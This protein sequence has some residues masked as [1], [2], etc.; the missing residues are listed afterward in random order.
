MLRRMLVIRC[1]PRWGRLRIRVKSGHKLRGT[2]VQKSS[3][4]RTFERV[5]YDI[6]NK[7]FLRGAGATFFGHSGIAPIRIAGGQDFRSD[8]ASTNPPVIREFF[9]PIPL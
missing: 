9:R 3:P 4:F 8:I 5:I 7:Y 2:L 6:E 1:K